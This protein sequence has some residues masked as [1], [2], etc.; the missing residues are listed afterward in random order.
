MKLSI[1]T[2]SFNSAKYIE[3]AIQSVLYQNYDNWEHII[4][5]GGS[6]DGTLDI[7][8]K[9]PHLKWIS[10]SDKGQSD[11]MNKAF[12]MS[13]GDIIGYLNAD[14]WFEKNIFLS[15]IDYFQTHNRIDLVVGNLRKIFRDREVLF[16]PSIELYEILNYWPCRFPG[17][18]VSYLY[19]RNVQDKIGDFPIENHFTMDYWFLLRVY[20]MFNI[21]YIN[22]LLGNFQCFDNKSQDVGRAK[23]NLKFVRDEFLDNHLIVKTMYKFTFLTGVLKKYTY[24]KIF[25]LKKY[26]KK[27]LI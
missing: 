14:D 9:F 25:N 20:Y 10:E 15:I 23:E 7:L 18:P 1:L 24:K 11:A 6:T 16:V 3:R 19:R 2:P 26:I 22:T 8:K 4:V 21:G 12:K 5:D 17:N 27:K 13:S